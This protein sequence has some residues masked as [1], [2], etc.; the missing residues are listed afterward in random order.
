MNT[1]DMPEEMKAEQ[2]ELYSVKFSND[3]N[4]F[5]CGYDDGSIKMFQANLGYERCKIQDPKV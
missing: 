3:S 2:R 4:H 5:A 1:R